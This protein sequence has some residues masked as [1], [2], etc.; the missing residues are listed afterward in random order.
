MSLRLKGTVGTFCFS[1]WEL[2]VV[3]LVMQLANNG[4]SVEGKLPR[5]WLCVTVMLRLL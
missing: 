5:R 2:I 3:W 1:E 4:Q